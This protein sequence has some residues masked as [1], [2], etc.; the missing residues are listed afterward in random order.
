MFDGLRHKGI[1]HHA[2]LF[3]IQPGVCRTGEGVFQQINKGP[4]IHHSDHIP[5]VLQRAV[6][7][8]KTAIGYTVPDL[9]SLDKRSRAINVKPLGFEF[10]SDW[11]SARISKKF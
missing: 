6:L 3:S 5:D 2:G 9:K 11:N 8:G 7:A 4:N 10:F 1:G